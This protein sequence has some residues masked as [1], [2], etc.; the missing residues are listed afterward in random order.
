MRPNF[1]Q[2]KSISNGFK[3]DFEL[4]KKNKATKTSKLKKKES[5]MSSE[6]IV[7]G[8]ENYDEPK[9]AR[10][11]DFRRSNGNFPFGKELGKFNSKYRD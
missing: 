3:T 1:I 11:I 2:I 9:R 10:I 8:G 5:F 6:A 4:F 7:K